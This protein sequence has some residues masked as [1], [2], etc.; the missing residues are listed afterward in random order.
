MAAPDSTPDLAVV[1]EESDASSSAGSGPLRPAA[2]APVRPDASQAPPSPRK[3]AS[4]WLVAAVAGLGAVLFLHQL[5]RAERLDARVLSLT[6]EL[7][8]TSG[9]LAITARQLTAHQAHLDEVRDRGEPLAGLW[10]SESSIYGRFG[11]GIAAEAHDLELDART[12]Q[13]AGDPPVG[14]VRLVDGPSASADRAPA[15]R[16]RRPP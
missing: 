12:V 11:F 8:E 10:A 15:V 3:G 1:S 2:S 4:W 5:Q 16:R 7:A 6:G 14:Q 13:F 9:Q